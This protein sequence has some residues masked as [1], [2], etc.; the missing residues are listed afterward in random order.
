M[1]SYAK[2]GDNYNCTSKDLLTSLGEE[3]MKLNDKLNFNFKWEKDTINIEGIS[4]IPIVKQSINSFDA[5]DG[6]QLITLKD[7]NSY[8]NFLIKTE[9]TFSKVGFV[10]ITYRCN[11]IN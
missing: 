4:K 11:K 5:F 7:N 6:K 8:N 2:I 3:I 9:T 1:T 10:F